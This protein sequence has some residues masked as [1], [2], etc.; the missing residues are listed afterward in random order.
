M[1]NVKVVYMAIAGV[2]SELSETGIKKNKENKFQ[3]FKF[4][5]IDDV[6]NALAP[7]LS[8]YGLVILPRVIER[9]CVERLTKK[10]EPIFYA[11][12]T[13]EFDL[14]AVEDGS[15]H[16]IRTV[17]EAMD[18]SDKAT[19]KAMSAAYK[20]AC[21]QAF[22][23]PTEGDNDADA[24]THDLQANKPQKPTAVAN[25]TSAKQVDLVKQIKDGCAHF[26]MDSKRYAEHNG[27]TPSSPVDVLQGHVDS[28]NKMI[29]NQALGKLTEAEQFAIEEYAA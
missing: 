4:R 22:C 29:E 7:L 3:G 17:G 15:M 25:K 23:I 1:S 5:G 6:Y 28:F 8:K 16:T 10:Q 9:E 26:G 14:V 2:A 27:L 11:T 20:Y 12:V 19:N 24:T 13:S 18:S 21:L